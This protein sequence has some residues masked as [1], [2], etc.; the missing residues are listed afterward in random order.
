[1]ATSNLELDYEFLP[2]L[3]VYKN[4]HVERL[5]GIDAI[6]PG[7]DSQFG[8]SSKDI[9][10]IVPN[11]EVYVRIYLPIN[12]NNKKLPLVI[13]FHG[14]GFCMFTPSSSLYHNY[15]NTL[16][17]ESRV[18]A[19]SVHYRRPPEH[20]VH[21]AYED[22]WQ[23]LQWVFAHCNG[24]G[25][26]PWLNEHANF[27][28]VF[29]SGDSAGANIAHNMAM[30]VGSVDPE[31][32]VDILGVALIHPYFW[33][34]DPIGSEGLYPDKK[35]GVDR[36]WSFVCPSNPDN[37]DPRVNPIAKGAPSLMSLG[38]RRILI[39]VAEKDILKDRG[40]A[41]YE[42]LGQSGWMGVV[43]IH[44]TQREDHVFHLHDLDSQK[45]KDLMKNLAHFFNRERT[46]FL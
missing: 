18:I 4:G 33:G 1:M 14:G 20:P 31:L 27:A 2:Y 45:S 41:Y 5:L 24:N 40:R 32:M 46:H 28:R 8:V 26:E 38:C 22:S 43:E 37:D 16:V 42:A 9:S 21:V 36:M 44:E 11:S 30:N 25:P 34:S 6:P 23:V 29:L 7:I 13:Y 19:I 17:S 15:L 39:C 12:C 35:A 10:N 3:K